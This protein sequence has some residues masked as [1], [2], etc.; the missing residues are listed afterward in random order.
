MASA[1]FRRAA[2]SARRAVSRMG[3]A[4]GEGGNDGRRGGCGGGGDG[5]WRGCRAS[6]SS[7]GRIRRRAGGRVRSLWG[8]W[9]AGGRGPRLV[10]WVMGATG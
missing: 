7:S 9:S 4:H 6:R 2:A 8:C 10:A 1:W 5:G 3:I